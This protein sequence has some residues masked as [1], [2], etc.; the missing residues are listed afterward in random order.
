M[1]LDRLIDICTR[2]ALDNRIKITNKKS[3]S[4]SGY[5]ACSS[6]VARS[7]YSI[8]QFIYWMIMTNI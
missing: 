5:G 6:N 3:V 7:T 1:L 2:F 4:R 8:M